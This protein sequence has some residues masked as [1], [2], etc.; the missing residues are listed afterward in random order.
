MLSCEQI[1]A[2]FIESEQKVSRSLLKKKMVPGNAYYGKIPDGG[3][4]P[5]HSG[6]RIKGRRLGR[7]TVPDDQGWNPIK[8]QLC[9]T[10]A[11]DFNPELM[12]HGSSDYFFSVVQRDIRTDWLCLDSL[13][14]RD[15]VEDEVGHLE[16]GLRDGSRYVHEEFRRSRYLL[17]CR[18]HNLAIIPPNGANT[19]PVVDYQSCQGNEV[20]DGAWV[21]E[22]R[23][24]GEMDES[25][26][27]VCINPL[28]TG[29]G[30]D[31]YYGQIGELTMDM[32]DLAKAQLEY[33][34]E[35]YLGDTGLWDVLLAE[36]R[37]ANRLVLQENA[38]MG[39]AA[40]N[41][42]GG[43]NL[44]D[45]RQNYGTERV[46]RDYSLR[47]DRYAMK[48]FPDYVFNV[49]LVA[50]LGYAFNAQDPATWPRFTR[51]YAYVPVKAQYAG[52]VF[53]R[54]PNFLRAPF[55]ISTI[56]NKRV[57]EVMS[58]PDTSGYG[59]ATYGDMFSW[60]GIAKWRNPD[61]ECNVKRNKGFW[62]LNFR[63]AAKQAYD[64][65]GYAW[66]H[67]INLGLALRGNTCVPNV[68]ECTDE[69]TPYCFDAFGGG[70]GDVDTGL[71]VNAAQN[72]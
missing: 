31:G 43:W 61:W 62:M 37:M 67:R 59:S 41:V 28:A 69:V 71:G 34:D 8:D 7:V 4:F 52:V 58:F 48:F 22:S 44:L 29:Y 46:I 27:R 45:L 6:T 12:H 24:S 72:N 60:D 33:E 36:Q 13:A 15:F 3:S 19:G 63:M 21:F 14:F 56:L 18:N 26:V 9:E 50:G 55:G 35:G 32:L 10:S 20:I 16:D 25:H 5:L 66:F 1:D 54:N 30:A 49:A 68:P 42:Q 57:M 11:C 47:T 53:Q 38:L 65:E 2:T 51:V 64:E 70:A 40:S 23:D 17:F 39:F